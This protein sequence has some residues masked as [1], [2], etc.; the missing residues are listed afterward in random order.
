MAAAVPARELQ[1]ELVLYLDEAPVEF[2]AALRHWLD[3]SAGSARHDDSGRAALT[4]DGWEQFLGQLQ[5][6][7][8]QALHGLENARGPR[9]KC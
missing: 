9:I 8:S 4:W 3:V 7:L 5:G 1:G 6:R 2:R